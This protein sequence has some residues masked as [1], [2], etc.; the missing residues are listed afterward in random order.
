MLT[1][2]GVE[3]VK[4]IMDDGQI[5]HEPVYGEFEDGQAEN[6]EN[7]FFVILPVTTGGTNE[8]A[9]YLDKEFLFVE[10]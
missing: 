5:L 7:L 6:E 4:E 3:Y 9:M 10:N 1:D 2:T 8:W